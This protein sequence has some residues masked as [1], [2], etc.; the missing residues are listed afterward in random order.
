MYLLKI[1]RIIEESDANQWLTDAEANII[2]G[3]IRVTIIT[4]KSC[5]LTC[6]TYV[7]R[8]CEI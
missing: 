8:G 1:E 5:Q 7:V 4:M 6:R 3:I 2:A